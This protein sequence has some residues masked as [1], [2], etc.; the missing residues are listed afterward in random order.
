MEENQ[1]TG[2]EPVT[3]D[4]NV[5]DTMSRYALSVV[6]VLV[7]VLGFIGFATAAYA[8]TPPVD[9]PLY[10]TES[11]FWF[12]ENANVYRDHRNMTGNGEIVGR[13]PWSSELYAG[14][15]IDQLG[16]DPCYVV[17]TDAS[18]IERQG[19]MHNGDLVEPQQGWNTSPQGGVS[20]PSYWEQGGGGSF[21]YRPGPIYM[22]AFDKGMNAGIGRKQEIW[23]YGYD[24]GLAEMANQV[25]TYNQE[26]PW[27]YDPPAVLL[28]DTYSYRQPAPLE[29]AFDPPAM[30]YGDPRLQGGYVKP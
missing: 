7:S 4:T 22:D 5:E 18:S 15:C 25:P 3:T 8:Q 23:G 6:A 17:H 1:L 16:I 24:A 30:S 28:V 2:S 19:W 11:S 29:F 10:Q 21:I 12:G 13:V 9:T 27:V 26:M 20:Q 14:A